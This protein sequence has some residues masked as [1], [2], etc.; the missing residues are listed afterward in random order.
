MST[1]MT[2]PIPDLR[3]LLA[4]ATPAPWRDSYPAIEGGNGRDVIALVWGCYND[5]DLVFRDEDKALIVAMRNHLLPLLDRVERAEAALARWVDHPSQNCGKP[6]CRI[7]AE[8]REL[9]AGRAAA[10][11]E[12]SR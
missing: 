10:A 6:S 11:L 7:V 8:T 9:L 2:D 12:E 5:C 1:D 3:R 4:E